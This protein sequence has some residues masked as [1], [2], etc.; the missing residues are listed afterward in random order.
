MIAQY[1]D[2]VEKITVESIQYKGEIVPVKGVT[3][4]WLSRAGQDQTGAPA[5]GLRL[6][7]VV[8]GGEIP[9]HDH[10]YVQTMYILSGKF[11]C[12][13]SDRESGEIVESKVVGPDDVVYIPTL[14]P[15]GMRNLSES[16]PGTFLC[17]IGNVSESG[18]ATGGC[19]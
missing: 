16:E 3:V 8:P 14:E 1:K 10:V 5:Y 7:T 13:R 18:T 19:G 4:Q 17:C 11:E 6:F 15:H 12:W 9:S 2:E